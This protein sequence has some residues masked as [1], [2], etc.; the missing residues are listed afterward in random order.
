M[1]DLIVISPSDHLTTT[2]P[3]GFRFTDQVFSE[4]AIKDPISSEQRINASLERT[5]RYLVKR[6]PRR[7]RVRWIN[8]WSPSGLLACFRYRVRNFPAVVINQDEVLFGDQLLHDALTQ[9]VADILSQ[10]I[11]E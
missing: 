9:K 8:P 6:F 10:S 11:D 7:I 2:M 1:I 3:N 5:L 4:A